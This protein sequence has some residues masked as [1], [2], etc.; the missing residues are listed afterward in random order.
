MRFLLLLIFLIVHG[1]LRAQNASN[2]IDELISNA[3]YEGALQEVESQLAN[4]SVS[5]LQILQ[6][7]KAQ[8]QILLGRLGEAET[9][10]KQIVSA[11]AFD[12]A[13][14]LSTTGYWQLNKSRFDLA[15]ETLQLAWVRFQTAQKQSTPQAA[16]CLSS[17]SQVYRIQGRQN[18]ALEFETMA[19]QIRQQ[20]FGDNS[21]QVAASYNELGL[22]YTLSDSDLDKALEMYEKAQVLYRKIHGENHP[23]LAIA[24]I[25]IGI[26]YQRL[27][28]YGDAINNF[29]TAQKIWAG[30]YPNGHPNQAIV[31]RNLATTYGLL[32]NEKAALS[33]FQQ[34]LNIY[35]R[36]YGEKHPDIAGTYNELGRFQVN[37]RRYEEAL[38]SYQQALRANT[39]SFAPADVKSNPKTGG[40]FYNETVG[41]FSLHL[42]AKAFEERHYGQTLKLEDL[43]LAL[44]GL[45]A[46]D[47]LIDDIRQHSSD[48]ADKLAFGALASEVYEDGVRVAHTISE[49]TLGSREFLH[50]AFYFAEK[51]KSAV[52]QESI[53]DAQAKAFAG[54]PTDLLENERQLKASIALLSQKISQKPIEAEERKLR[55]ALFTT[56]TQYQRFIKEL[57][58]SYPNYFNLKYNKNEVTVTALQQ[59]LKPRSGLVS[60]FIADRGKRIYQFVITKTKF[61]VKSMALPPDFDRYLRGFRNSLLHSSMSTYKKATGELQ[62]ALLPKVSRR[63]NQ[64]VI[65][66]SGP[67]ATVPFEALPRKRVASRDFDQIDY[68]IKSVGVSYDFSAN[69]FLQKSRVNTRKQEP[70]VFLCAPVTFDPD[71]NL[72]AL[73]ASEKE[74]TDIANLFPQHA[75][76]VKFADA[77]EAVVKSKDLLQYSYLH[78]ATHGV[79]DEENPAASR[80]FLNNSASEDGN[81]FAGE[82]YSL[83]LN[84]NLAVL[85]A[86][87]TGLGKISKG[88]GVIGLSRALI[89]AGAKNIVVSFWAVAD[90]ST[91][92]LM[93][94]FYQEVAARPS[95]DFNQSLQSAKIKMIEQK[96]FAK[97]F[98]WAPFVLIGN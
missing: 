92:Q 13:I 56:N 23:K 12:Q 11:D 89:Y 31:L 40:N 33:Y 38:Q 39:I 48:E 65:I 1:C 74:V 78:F 51:S 67:L 6:N 32:N 95:Q 25:N 66:P 62:R 49:L 82:I 41:L 29:E 19:L 68:L 71:Q 98:Y 18:Q 26:N 97:P 37:N 5:Q 8:V 83:S 28:L 30:I 45:Y 53:V 44:S 91:A 58:K 47:S 94:K 27:K 7:K 57:E 61:R 16:D 59:V 17:L 20:Q 34:S 3:N 24:A 4:A 73:P 70:S 50:R 2:R 36:S 77:N 46:C 93:T 75:K 64:L 87:Q 76:A 90:E 81:L 63:V 60:Y 80:I 22:I 72:S 21:E 43:K 35:K 85:S 84:A 42:K 55:E 54:I 69:L 14:T 88:E 79:V 96:E 9:T 86:C 52:L 15:V 10:L